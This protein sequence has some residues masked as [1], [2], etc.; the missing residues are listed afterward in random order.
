ML[1]HANLRDRQT[2]RQGDSLSVYR[3]K[4][5]LLWRPRMLKTSLD[6]GVGSGRDREEGE[7]ERTWLSAVQFIS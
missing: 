1:T 5:E 3:Q 2:D 6:G 4:T 7:S